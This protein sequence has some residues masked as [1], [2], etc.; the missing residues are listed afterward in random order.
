MTRVQ[1]LHVQLHAHAHSYY[2]LDDPSIPDAEYDRLF[3][4]LQLLEAQ[5][6]ELSLTRKFYARRWRR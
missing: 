4:E 1:E 5:H 2:V 3:K 6:P